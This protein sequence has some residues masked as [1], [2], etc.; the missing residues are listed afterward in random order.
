MLGIQI[1]IALF[2]LF[3]VVRTI[4][5]FRAGRL[6]ALW[7]AVWLVFWTV[8]VVLVFLPNTTQILA[9]VLGVGRGAD[10]VIYVALVA[11]FY[12]QFKLFVKLESVEQEI[13]TL[14]RKVALDDEEGL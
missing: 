3:A 5:Q 10:L 8:V 7:G 6:S 4:R 2:A 14:V 13:S 12:L 9:D 1:L 11:L